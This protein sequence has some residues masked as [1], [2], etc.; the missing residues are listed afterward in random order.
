MRFRDPKTLCELLCILHICNNFVHIVKIP[1]K[2]KTHFTI[3]LKIYTNTKK[4]KATIIIGLIHIK[5]QIHIFLELNQNDTEKKAWFWIL[6][7]VTLGTMIKKC[8][9]ISKKIALYPA[10]FRTTFTNLIHSGKF[11]RSV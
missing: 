5:F 11:D 10:D 7:N 9:K 8:K 4:M 6:Q 2:Y 3:K 1:S